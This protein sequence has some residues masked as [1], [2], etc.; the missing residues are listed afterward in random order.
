M[1]RKNKMT[2]NYIVKL[3]RENGEMKAKLSSQAPIVPG[4]PVAPVEDD[5]RSE[6]ITVVYGANKQNMRQETIPAQEAFDR[7]VEFYQGFELSTNRN[8]PR[9]VGD[10]KGNGVA[11]NQTTVYIKAKI[12]DKIQRKEV[13]LIREVPFWLAV[14]KVVQQG[15]QVEL[16]SKK[17]WDSWMIEEEK[18]DLRAD[19]KT[20]DMLHKARVRKQVMEEELNKAGV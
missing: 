7:A 17:E 19:M 12:K 6:N 10:E 13:S 2:E 15:Q 1:S 8:I 20:R 11:V 3:K 14:D 16:I 5:Y 9:E 18:K 4:A